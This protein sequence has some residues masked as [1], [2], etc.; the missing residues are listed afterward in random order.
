MEAAQQSGGNY[1]STT[2]CRAVAALQIMLGIATPLAL[3]SIGGAAI[4]GAAV[5]LP[6]LWITAG[7]SGEVGRWYFTVLAAL[8]AGEISWVVTWSLLPALQL[9]VPLIVMAAAPLAF[10]RTF[11]KPLKTYEY[12]VVVIVLA[13]IGLAG[14]A[15]LSA[16][17]STRIRE[18]K[19]E[20]STR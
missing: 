18:T 2:L 12:V 7:A 17:S 20:Q 4:Y 15:S 1:H 9:L 16:G 10:R 8:V 13:L 6:L 3:L 5:L 11:S 19:F 14:V